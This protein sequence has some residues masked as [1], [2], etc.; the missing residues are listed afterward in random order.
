[1]NSK[2]KFD[3]FLQ[4]ELRKSSMEFDGEDFREQVLNNLPV[5]AHGN[6]IRNLILFIS[7]I[8]ACVL[9]F[10]VIDVSIITNAMAE[11]FFF[12]N[13]SVL[14]SLQTV[15]LVVML[16]FVFVLIPRIE[17]NTGIG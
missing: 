16:G 17:F 11:I 3:T 4:D 9:F 15:L 12:I 8:V 2:D 14:P 10:V 6:R 13:E 1:M 5:Y 7:G